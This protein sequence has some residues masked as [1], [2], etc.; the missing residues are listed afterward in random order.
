MNQYTQLTSISLMINDQIKALTNL[1]QLENYKVVFQCEKIY[2]LYIQSTISD[3]CRFAV[4][5]LCLR[6]KCK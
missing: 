6:K 1:D 2:L 3:V 5:A 4:K